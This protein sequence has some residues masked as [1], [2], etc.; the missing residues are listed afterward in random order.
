MMT[1]NVFSEML[2]KMPEGTAASY[3]N[4]WHLDD[5]FWK[6]GKTVVVI[7]S[8]G[9]NEATLTTITKVG[10]KYV[11]ALGKRFYVM[12]PGISR[13]IGSAKLENPLV[14]YT[15]EQISELAYMKQVQEVLLK[16]V[17]S[18]QL[19]QIGDV[20]GIA[21]PKHLQKVR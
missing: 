4:H 14:L 6:V 3:M 2:G 16:L 11:T 1:I 18:A 7:D 9:K 17:M 8:K 20:L 5:K 19:L 21:R 13:Q 15:L 10:K 12:K